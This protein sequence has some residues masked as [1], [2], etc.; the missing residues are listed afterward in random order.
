[1]SRTLSSSPSSSASDS[2]RPQVALL[3]ETSNAYARGLLEGI[4]AYLREHRPWSIYLSEH[5][6]GDAV[7]GWLRGWKGDGIIARIEN[8][9]IAHAVAERNLPTVDVSAARL[10][11]TIPVVETDNPLIA[12]MAAGHLLERGFQHLGFCGVSSYKWSQARS[13]AFA[14][15][16][17]DA[18]RSFHLHQSPD[19]LEAAADNLALAR[20]V[21]ALPKPVGIMAA[22]DIRGR[23]LLDACRTAAIRV[24]DDVAVIGV[25]DDALLCELADPPLSSIAPDTHRTGYIAAQLLEQMME[26]GKVDELEYHIPPLGI[27][28]RRSSDALAIGDADVCGALRYIRD[29]ACEGIS[30]DDVLSQTPLSRRV[31]ESR[32]RRLLGRS[33][34]QEILRVRV[35]R[36]KRLLAETDLPIKAIAKK[37]GIPHTEY[38]SVTFKRIT[39]RS[40]SEYRRSM[41]DL[42]SISRSD[43][44]KPLNRKAKPGH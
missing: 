18:G 31:L 9:D 38:L 4:A 26:G 12:R 11:P 44:S 28:T 6:R 10:L 8:P 1:M 29:H 43:S 34:H 20:W 30:V 27:V 22:Y 35:E 23:Q 16:A 14:Q 2:T 40:P 39:G 37:S 21:A 25:D 41:R 36:V 32:F 19:P 5:G 33:P 24:P 17:R 15:S 13:E 3:I 7:P 42:S